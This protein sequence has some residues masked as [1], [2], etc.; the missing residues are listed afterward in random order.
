MAGWLTRHP[1]CIESCIATKPVH[2][3][4]LLVLPS[5]DLDV[6]SSSSF[7]FLFP[8]L[9]STS[10]FTLLPRLLL[11][12]PSSAYLLLAAQYAHLGAGWLAGWL[13][14]SPSQLDTWSPHKRILP[15]GALLIRPACLSDLLVSD[16]LVLCEPVVLWSSVLCYPL[17]SL[18]IIGCLLLPSTVFHTLVPARASAPSVPLSPTHAHSAFTVTGLPSNSRASYSVLFPT[19]L[20][21]T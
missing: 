15:C 18:A 13:D 16:T 7:F 17:P 3:P 19:Y 8:C 21:G 11:H 14:C 9:F 10:S 1:G 4:P 2:H 12:R 6:L 20:A 5:L